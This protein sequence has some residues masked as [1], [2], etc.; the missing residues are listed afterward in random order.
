MLWC[1]CQGES[2]PAEEHGE[3]AKAETPLATAGAD[4]ALCGTDL[5]QISANWAELG[6]G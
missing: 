3:F 4:A 6:N 5:C 1:L 2:L